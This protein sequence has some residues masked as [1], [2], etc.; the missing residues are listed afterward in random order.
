[1]TS[2][3]LSPKL[4]VRTAPEKGGYAVY[5]GT[6]L[7]KG[8]LLAIWGGRIATLEQVLALPHAEQGH[9]IQVYDGLYLAP[10]DME[11]PADFIN[12]SCNPNAGICG[13]IA[14]VAMRDIQP[15]EE[16]SFDYAMADSSS[17]D[18]FD[19]ACGAPTCRE[20]V[21]GDD[22]MRPELWER[23]DGYFSSYL[24]KRIDHL[25]GKTAA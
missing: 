7:K 11:E 3:F 25:R 12:H 4:E 10:I 19:C 17:F 14:L 16:I 20:L 6:A 18:E 8:E 22:W 5:A 15:G 1:M 21:S 24:Q 23:Y 13:Q 9:T 2:G